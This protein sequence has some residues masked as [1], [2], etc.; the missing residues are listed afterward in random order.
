M[1]NIKKPLPII[2]FGSLG[3]GKS[4]LL[5]FLCGDKDAF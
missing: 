2:I 5:N 1:E 3:I 4:T